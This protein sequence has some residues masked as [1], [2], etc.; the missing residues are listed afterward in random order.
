MTF[1]I[2]GN[3][4]VMSLLLYCWTF[5]NT[6]LTLYDI[7]IWTCDYLR[8]FWLFDLH[9]Y[10]CVRYVIVYELIEFFL[11]TIARGRQVVY[12]SLSS[13]ETEEME[14]SEEVEETEEEAWSPS[15]PPA[16]QRHRGR[17][18]RH[19]EPV[20]F[21]SARFFTQQHQEWY[22][23]HANLEFLFEKHVSFEVETVF[24]ISEA[25]DQLG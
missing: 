18:A 8:R 10:Q 14:N 1:A 6:Q 13:E 24:Q 3:F 9:Y 17:T 20:I 22:K 15:P 19:T 5:L 21:D 16:P 12:S 7:G 4:T 2:F 23:A 25:F 11:G